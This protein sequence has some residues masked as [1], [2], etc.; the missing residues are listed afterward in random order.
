MI[1]SL[2]RD[3]QGE[4]YV[5]YLDVSLPETLRRHTL[6][7]QAAEFTGEDMQGWY[8]PGDFLGC[9]GEHIIGEESSFDETLTLIETTAGLIT[10]GAA[11]VPQQG[12]MV[13]LP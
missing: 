2:L 5:Y 1:T 10:A 8:L 7:P 6:R 11:T 4:S 13:P 9:D 3:H 12:G